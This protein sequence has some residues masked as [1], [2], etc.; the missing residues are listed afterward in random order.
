MRANRTT[1]DPRHGA[2]PIGRDALAPH[3]RGADAS[4]SG[5]MATRLNVERYGRRTAM[6][7]HLGVVIAVAVGRLAVG[8]PLTIPGIVGGTV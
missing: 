5:D 8:R 1:Y 4:T 6:C 2:A 3:D 7:V